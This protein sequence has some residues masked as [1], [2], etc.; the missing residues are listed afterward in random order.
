MRRTRDSIRKKKG[1]LALRKAAWGSRKHSA[2]GSEAPAP[3]PSG[4]LKKLQARLSLGLGY[5]TNNIM[6]CRAGFPFIQIRFTSTNHV[7]GSVP[8]LGIQP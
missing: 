4:H 2:P 5:S 8:G 1:R 3:G 6:D 7:P